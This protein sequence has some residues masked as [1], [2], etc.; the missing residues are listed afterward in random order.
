MVPMERSVASLVVMTLLATGI[1]SAATDAAAPSR[2]LRLSEH[3]AVPGQVIVASGAGAMSKAKV[4]IGGKRARVV[5][6]GRGKLRVEVPRLRPGRATLVVRARGRRLTAKLRIKRG[7]SGR[8]RPKLDAAAAASAVIGS[9]GG[10]VRARAADGTTYEL[11]VPPGALVSPETL[12]LTPVAKLGSMP[13]GEDALAV[14]LAPDGLTFARPATLRIAPPTP[15]GKRAVGLAYSGSGGDLE[16][17]PASRN[18]RSLAVEVSH[19]SGAGATTISEP[20]FER[21]VAQLAAAPVTLE[22]AGHFFRD[23]RAVPE[24]WCDSAHPTCYAVMNEILDFLGRLS[25]NDCRDF[26][27]GSFI[28]LHLN[29]L[30]VLLALEGDARAAGRRLS[31]VADCRWTLTLAMFDLTR[32]AARTDALG[33]SDPCSGVRLANGD[34]DGSGSIVKVECL[35]L[36]AAE[37]EVQGFGNIAIPARTV[38]GEGLQKVLGEGEAKCD[39]K[40]YPGGQALLKPGLKLAAAIQILSQE[41]GEALLACQ[42]K[43]T[44]VPGSPSVEVHKTQSFTVTVEDPADAAVDWTA[45]G[46]DIDGTTGQFTAPDT[47]GT[48]TVTA[49]S[50]ANPERHGSTTVTIVCPPGQVDDQGQCKTVTIAISPTSAT[51]APGDQQQFTGT[52]TGSSDTRVIWSQTCGSVTQAGLYTAPLTNGTCTVKVASVPFPTLQASA[53]VAVGDPGVRVTDRLAFVTTCAAETDA[54]HD[55]PFDGSWTGTASACPGAEAN[56]SQTSDVRASAGGGGWLDVDSS[57]SAN[58]LDGPAASADSEHDVEFQVGDQPVTLSCT[59]SFSSTAGGLNAGTLVI[60]I[61][62]GDLL[63]M[64]SAGQAVDVSRSFGPDETHELRITT[65][66]IA[67]EV[68]SASASSN[69]TCDFDAPVAIDPNLD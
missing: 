47:P 54:R 36:V 43:I 37:A 20:D 46:G 19:F 56:A 7:F 57:T 5:S 26:A 61:D 63:L 31:K 50:R 29:V 2:G 32:E 10:V 28:D 48:V 8:V 9:A 13:G 58:N 39:A 65:S 55:D 53:T 64:A 62:S 60:R 49:T 59:G 6:R 11:A 45:S 66:S 23:Y 12:T 52:V 18:G 42:P 35:L 14:Q 67:N 69:I 41:F 30:R 25:A 68:G 3:T 51:L 1:A 16:L 24:E 34:Y 38:A 44:V 17:A 15:R 4:T 22:S 40:D 33:A 21:L 27:G